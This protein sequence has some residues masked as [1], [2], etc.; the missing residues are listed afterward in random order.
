MQ[1]S[2]RGLLSE[3]PSDGSKSLN[4]A[5]TARRCDA[6]GRLRWWKIKDR[7]SGVPV[8]SG[9]LALEETVE[10]A[11]AKVGTVC[12]LYLG[13]SVLEEKLQVRDG[14]AGR[15]EGAAL[16]LA[17]DAALLLCEVGESVHSPTAP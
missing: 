14:G 2:V 7:S 15:L 5:N 9:P 17:F 16:A 8:H 10:C 11:A 4:A 13:P 12:D 6:S 3:R 1:P